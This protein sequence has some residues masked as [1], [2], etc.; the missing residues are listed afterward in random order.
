MSYLNRPIVLVSSGLCTFAL[1]GIGGVALAYQSNTTNVKQVATEAVVLDQESSFPW[2]I[3]QTRNTDDLTVTKVSAFNGIKP[4]VPLHSVVVSHLKRTPDLKSK[5][6]F[7]QNEMTSWK[8]KGSSL[9][10]KLFVRGTRTYKSEMAV[11]N[12]SISRANGTVISI[13]GGVQ[14]LHW[15]SVDVDLL[16]GTATLKGEGDN[17]ASYAQWQ[18]KKG[19][20][21]VASPH[22][23]IDYTVSLKQVDGS[24]KVSDLE[25]TFAPG[26]EP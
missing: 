14:D 10:Q 17:W 5:V 4:R 1:L 15:T 13:D 18:P 25:W 19:R 6:T 23:L 26:S 7:T 12:R 2:T 8:Q 21:I 24:W 16:H 11:L 3:D 20:Y 22:N 9:I